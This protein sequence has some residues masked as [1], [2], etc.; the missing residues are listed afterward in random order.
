[1]VYNLRKFSAG[2]LACI[3]ACVM[4]VSGIPSASAASN[5]QDVSYVEELGEGYSAEVVISVDPSLT[6]DTTKTCLLYTSDAA[7]EL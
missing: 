4:V 6:R 5:S 3:L 2:A 1:M 7:D